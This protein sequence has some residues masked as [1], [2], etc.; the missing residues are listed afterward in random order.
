MSACILDQ[1]A[2]LRIKLNLRLLLIYNIISILHH[3]PLADRG[4]LW[5]LQK[6]WVY[7]ISSSSLSPCYFWKCVDFLSAVAFYAAA[8]NNNTYNYFLFSELNSPK[9][10]PLSQDFWEPKIILLSTQTSRASV[11]VLWWDLEA[12]NYVSC[13]REKTKKNLTL[14][15]PFGFNNFQFFLWRSEEMIGQFNLTT[16]KKN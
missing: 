5:V 7:L 6:I 13:N 11:E 1:N 15:D 16:L 2:P 14:L 9:R 3:K 8:K 12:R 10:G 4:L